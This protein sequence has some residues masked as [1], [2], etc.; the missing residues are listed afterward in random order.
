MT[1]E[2]HTEELLVNLDLMGIVH[3]QFLLDLYLLKV[4]KPTLKLVEVMFMILIQ[5]KNI[6][7]LKEN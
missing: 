1:E 4:R 6:L 7:K 5:K 3:L 2:A